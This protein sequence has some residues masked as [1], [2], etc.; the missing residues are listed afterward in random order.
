MHKL[1]YLKY[2]WLDIKIIKS[3]R[4]GYSHLGAFWVRISKV[5][6][7]GLRIWIVGFFPENE[8]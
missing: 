4:N 6:P 1:R 5:S 3:I 2:Y 8:M 7:F